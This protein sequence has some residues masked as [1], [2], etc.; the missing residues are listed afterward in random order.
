MEPVMAEGP[1]RVW[2]HSNA[3]SVETKRTGLEAGE[4]G[5]K[6]RPIHL[7]RLAWRP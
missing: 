3:T 2:T 5:R 6:P 7:D 4:P 1:H